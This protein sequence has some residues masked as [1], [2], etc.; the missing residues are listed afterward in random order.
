[1]EKVIHIVKVLFMKIR[2]VILIMIMILNSIFSYFSFENFYGKEDNIKY[3]LLVLGNNRKVESNKR[4]HCAKEITDLFPV[5]KIIFSGKGNGID[6]F[7]SE[8][9]YMDS[10][11]KD[12]YPSLAKSIVR[13]IEDNSMNTFDNVKFSLKFISKKENVIIISTHKDRRLKVA[14][15]NLSKWLG[16]VGEIAY[17]NCETNKVKKTVYRRRVK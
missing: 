2:E 7:K 5:D 8:A 11:F 13:K 12:E 16:G 1:M 17:C 9:L 10:F 6:N 14:S 3:T 4:V 15:K